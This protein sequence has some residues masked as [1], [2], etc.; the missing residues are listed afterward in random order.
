MRDIARTCLRSVSDQLATSA[1][2]ICYYKV[3][4]CN[5]QICTACVMVFALSDRFISSG[6]VTYVDASH[7]FSGSSY[8]LIWSDVSHLVAWGGVPNR[9]WDVPLVAQNLRWTCLL[10]E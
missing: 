9:N 4:A 1:I 6:G 7:T 5:S 3:S 2:Y 8:R 10:V